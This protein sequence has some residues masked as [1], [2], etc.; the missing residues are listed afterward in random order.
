ME[1]INHDVYLTPYTK[2]NL[3]WIIVLNTKTKAMKPVKENVTKHLHNLGKTKISYRSHKMVN[4]KRIKMINWTSSKFKMSA[5]WK[6]SL[7]KLKD[8]LQAGKKT[9]AISTTWIHIENL[10]M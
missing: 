9:F 5:L 1:K 10:P 7:G 4:H 2:S 8:K 6:T 3:K